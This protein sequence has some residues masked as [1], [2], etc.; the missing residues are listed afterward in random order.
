MHIV[1]G[2]VRVQ[3]TL[4]SLATSRLTRVGLSTLPVLPSTVRYELER[5]TAAFA[6]FRLPDTRVVIND[7]DAD[8]DDDNDNDDDDVNDVQGAGAC[9]RVHKKPRGALSDL[10]DSDS[11]SSVAAAFVGAT[12]S[13]T[14]A[15]SSLARGHGSAPPVLSPRALQVLR[16]FGISAVRAEEL[17]RL[18]V[19]FN[20]IC[21]QLTKS[22]GFRSPIFPLDVDA[23][24]ID[25]ASIQGSTMLTDQLVTS[26][27]G[28]C[29]AAAPP[30][31]YSSVLPAYFPRA[32][33]PGSGASDPKAWVPDNA[34][35]ITLVVSAK[36]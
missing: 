32:V 30:G 26:L 19:L 10:S 25:F 23:S 13:S 4:L 35:I 16:L 14:A 18:R 8:D 34:P 12:A 6:A 24:N 28:V 17:V 31:L 29:I 3:R 11:D 9:S 21:P 15:S 22:V 33:V 27:V 5:L 36:Q 1:E 7:N 2:L 20:Q